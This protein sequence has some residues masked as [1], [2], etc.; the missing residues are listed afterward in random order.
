MKNFYNTGSLRIKFLYLIL[1][2]TFLSYE[3]KA[4]KA[5]VS[6]PVG[7]GLPCN[8]NP[9]NRVMDSLKYFNFN[10]DINE[11][12]TRSICKPILNETSPKPGFSSNFASITFNP[13]DGYLYFTQIKPVSGAYNSYTYRW[14]PTSCPNTAPAVDV[15]QTF[16][17]Q[18][19]A[20]VEFDAA[21]G[22]G[23]QIN[24][25]G[26]AAPFSMELQ[27]VNF[28]TGVLGASIPINFG[29]RYIYQ[30]NGD[31]VMTPGG[32]LLAIFDNKYFTVN[33]KD[34]GTAPLV[35]TF[36]D[37]LN[38]GSGVAL[39]GLS[40]S[41]GKLIAA[42]NGSCPNN[43]KQIDILTGAQ[44]PISYNAPALYNGSA[45]YKSTDMTNLPSGIGAAKNLVSVT[46]NP[47]GS[48]IYDVYYDIKIKNYGGTPVTNVQVFDTLNKING[49]ANNLSGS[50]VSI[51]GPA[52]ITA[53]PA[54]NGKTNFALLTPGGTL[55]NIPG[56]NTIDIRI[57][58]RVANVQPGIIYYNQAVVTAVGLLGDALRDSSTNGT[59]PDLNLN[60]KPD[61]VGESQPTPFLISVAAI[62]PPCATLTKILYTQ[63][64]GSG[65]P[66]IT[67]IPAAT[68]GAGVSGGT[69]TTG[70]TGTL[71][72]PIPIERYMLVDTARK[73]DAANF[74]PLRDHTGNLNGRMLLVNADANNNV[75]YK[76]SITMTGSLCANQQY[77]LSF[78]AAFIGNNKYQT[79]CDAFGGFTFPK[80]KMRIR[81]AVAAGNPII[82]EVSTTNITNTNWQQ[83]GLKFVSPG[84]YTGII[85]ELIN[86]APGG[87][88]N[89]LVIDDIQF[90]SCDPEPTVSVDALT[91]GCLG[92]TTVFSANLSDASAI[93]GPKDYQWEVAPA[94]AGPWATITG[95]TNATYTIL[96]VGASHVGKYYRVRV[97]AAGNLGIASCEYISP[98]I[99]L[100]SKTLSVAATTATKNKNNI[101]PGI[102][103]SLGITGGT[104]GTNAT[105]KWYSAD[106]FSG[107]YVGTGATINVSPS[108][109]TTYYVRAEG[110]CN[111]TNCQQVTVFISCDL[112]KDKDGIP[113][114][115]ESYTF[116]IALTQAFN[117]AYAGYV[118]NN[119][120]FVNDNFQADGDSDN[121]GIPNYLDTDFPGRI[122]SNGDG[123]DDRFDFDLDGIINMLD[124]DSDNDGIPDVVEAGGVD[125]NGDGKLDNF[126]D[127]DNDGISQ[128]VDANNTGAKNS[129]NGLGAVNLDNDTNPNAIDLDSD[130]DGIPDVVEAEG[131]DSNN[132]GKID[133]FV[134]ANADGLHDSYIN[135]TGLLRTGPDVNNDGR[136]DSY[137]YKNFDNDKRPN[138]YDID[139]DADGITDVTEA[140]FIDGVN[141]AGA[142]G[143]IDGT[144]GTN[145]W[146]TTISALP[147]LNLRNTDGRGRPDYMDIDSDDDG[148]PDNIE[149]M[150]TATYKLPTGLDADNDGLDNAYDAF[151]PF[152]SA[153]GG[154][155]N[156][157]YDHDFD[158]IPD[159]RDLDSDSDGAPDITEGHD[160]NGNGIADD[161]A[162]LSGND[163]DGDGLDDTFDAINSTT[164]LYG[165]SAFMGN[166]GSLVGDATP[167][168]KCT[169]QKFNPAQSDRDWRYTM[170][171]LDVQL[172]S[173][174]ASL[175][176]NTTL[177]N[178]SLISSDQIH[179]FEIERSLNNQNFVSIQQLQKNVP[180]Q[181]LTNFFTTDDLQYVDATEVYYRLKIVTATGQFKYSSVVV[182][183]L[184]KKQ[185]YQFAVHPNPAKNLVKA[186][187]V[188]ESKS[189]ATIRL[190]DNLGK[191]ILIQ[192]EEVVKGNNSISITG[193]QKYANAVYTLQIILPDEVL[194]QK[195]IIHNH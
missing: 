66:N 100:T 84:S 7:I 155:G 147:A 101:C 179:H 114:W 117:T 107:T 32:Q 109:T 126:T 6:I 113:D 72:S 82:T 46:E 33:W 78:Y 19:V 69:Q 184:S 96:S 152:A 165:T 158:G 115:V 189:I 111:I 38:F 193:L 91:G 119:N 188:S 44:S 54:F 133:G 85:F 61:D 62:T 79:V 146:S 34:Y 93:P 148:I 149:G 23:Y 30:Q 121:D 139:S 10:G 151:G 14:L 137:P 138:C 75:I 16:V 28:A 194:T 154:A 26:A 159:Y 43:Y 15:Y 98:G 18:F 88:G 48:K 90:G 187:F 191:T 52:G 195:L 68:L 132:D 112:D 186:S 145:G 104:L 58:C 178:W 47:V 77:S 161:G 41:S 167:G 185:N 8:A 108:V 57:A 116:P 27:Q 143:F 71:T 31:V 81:D 13:H 80:I 192:K 160:Y 190:M 1:A 59:N 63:N 86:D 156:Y 89:D 131:P 42:V 177:L 12:S 103:V 118:D 4:Q 60:D 22:L 173:F 166:N 157:P 9:T 55:S 134:D 105:W 174:N 65:I 94:L 97:A 163:A 171:V 29:G 67:A 140:G 162:F 56:Q 125:E 120:D 170:Y 124:L 3:S 128:T 70:Y 20:G 127:T 153:F 136:A 144:I 176:N 83:Y 169:V 172:L 36:I 130:N 17:N 11:L 95:E 164:D 49:F 183:R 106:C 150:S 40:Y 73:A 50:I 181:Q 168:S 135:A 129:G 39:V 64:F 53:N 2:L 141:G 24:F 99:L 76:G 175:Q 37:T 25:T 142:D 122:D 180:L 45:A 21:T 5:T 51:I 123:V 87:C 110:D 92:Y 102:V 74:L 35:A 182:V